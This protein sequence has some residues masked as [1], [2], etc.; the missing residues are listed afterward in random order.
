MNLINDDYL[1][2]VNS[3]Q[4]DFERLVITLPR[5]IASATEAAAVEFA[6]QTVDGGMKA[7]MAGNLALT[8]FFTAVIYF[9]WGMINGMQVISLTSLFRVRLP[10]N[11]YT[12]MIQILKLS[13]FD[14]FQTEIWY[15]AIFK[16]SENQAFSPIFEEAELEGSNFIMG[17]GPMFMFMFFYALFLLIRHFVMKCSQSQYKYVRKVQTV[18]IE[19]R[20]ESTVI[21]FILEGGLDILLWALIALSNVYRARAFG[22]KF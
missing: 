20:V 8:I 10:P 16:F 12:V 2:G 13:A 9:L 7:V 14:L 1:V 19:H 5:Q 17:I 6:A 22:P 11:V 15:K 3:K 18:F 21:R 4:V